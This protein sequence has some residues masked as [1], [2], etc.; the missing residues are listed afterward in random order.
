[1]NDAVFFFL[2][3][4]LVTGFIL[5]QICHN[6]LY[7]VKDRKTNVVYSTVVKTFPAEFLTLT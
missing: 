6:Y 7:T 2:S 5:N 4:K 1:M 3:P